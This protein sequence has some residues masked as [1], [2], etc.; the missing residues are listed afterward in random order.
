MH[1]AAPLY[2]ECLPGSQSAHL[3]A[4][5]EDWYVPPLHG[6]HSAS[7]D[8]AAT[9]PG[10]QGVGLTEPMVLMLP[11][12]ERRHSEAALSCVAFEYLPAGHNC[13]NALPAGQKAPPGHGNDEAVAA[14]GQ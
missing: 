8:A 12:G 2:E 11:G 7:P 5:G 6:T 3:V 10:E 9:V 1:A 14:V 13:G 4:L